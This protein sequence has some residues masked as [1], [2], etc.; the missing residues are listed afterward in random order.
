MPLP[1]RLAAACRV[2]GIVLPTTV[3][4]YGETKAHRLK[5]ERHHAAVLDARAHRQAGR[6]AS[7]RDRLRILDEKANHALEVLQRASLGAAA[8]KAEQDKAE[9]ELASAQ[10]RTDAARQMLNDMAAS[11]YR[12]ISSGGELGATMTL[13]DSGDPQQFLE[14]LQVIGQVGKSESRAVDELRVA[15]AMQLRAESIAQAA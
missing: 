14:G 15:E 11:A 6:L 5:R 8:A 12:S 2:L 10:K 9:A 3:P 13:V 4:S 7:L 1:R